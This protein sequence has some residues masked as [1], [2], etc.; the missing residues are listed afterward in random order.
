MERQFWRNI[1]VEVPKTDALDTSD[2]SVD[3]LDTSDEEKIIVV[4]GQYRRV[5]R[6][7]RDNVAETGY[8]WRCAGCDVI[9]VDTQL[10][11]VRCRASRP[12]DSAALGE[13]KSRQIV[14]PSIKPRQPSRSVRLAVSADD[15]LAVVSSARTR[16]LRWDFEVVSRMSRVCRAWREAFLPVLR[17][18]QRAHSGH[19]SP[20]RRPAGPHAPPPPLPA[21]PACTGCVL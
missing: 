5:D 3:E 13:W 19:A 2:E 7:F 21:V 4:N 17:F 9:N 14:Q 11:C 16:A 15:V 18:A 12:L 20:A 10:A 6:L 8:K 1:A